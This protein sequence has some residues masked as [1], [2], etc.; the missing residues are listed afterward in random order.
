M[1][2]FDD[3]FAAESILRAHVSDGCDYCACGHRYSWAEDAPGWNAEWA[4]HV[5]EVLTKAGF[6]AP[7]PVTETD[8]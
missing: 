6:L 8:K 4:S 5:A 2:A 3:R 1:S 7:L